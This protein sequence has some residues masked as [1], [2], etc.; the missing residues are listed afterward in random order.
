V[1]AAG[2][3]FAEL[4]KPMTRAMRDPFGGPWKVYRQT[5]SDIRCLSVLLVE[6]LFG[7]ADAQGLPPVPAKLG[8]TRKTLW[9]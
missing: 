6:R 2:E 5:A 8:R 9:R 7:V 4:P 1:A 3:R